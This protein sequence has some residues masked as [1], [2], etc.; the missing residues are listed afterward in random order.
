MQNGAQMT[1]AALLHVSHIQKLPYHQG[2]YLCKRGL[3]NLRKRFVASAS[4]KK[5]TQGTDKPL[6][7]ADRVGADHAGAP[8]RVDG[9]GENTV[10]LVQA[11]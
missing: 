9:V 11:D 6:A 1:S 10:L 3:A 2:L 8:L 4:P 7:A 5:H